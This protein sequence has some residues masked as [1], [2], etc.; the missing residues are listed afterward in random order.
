MSFSR[1]A[2]GIAARYLFDF[3]RGHNDISHRIIRQVPRLKKKPRFSWI[4]GLAE[5][6][7]QYT[8]L[9]LQKKAFDWRD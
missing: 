6:R 2:S 1:T 9:E 8:A 4:G 3:A 5:F 7:D